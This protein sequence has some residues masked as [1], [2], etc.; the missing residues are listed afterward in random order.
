MDDLVKFQTAQ[1]LFKAKNK[2]LPGNI[3]SM[4]FLKEGS[5]NLRGFVTSKQGRYELQEKAFVFLFMG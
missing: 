4:F 3:Q 5:Y 2:E 1:I